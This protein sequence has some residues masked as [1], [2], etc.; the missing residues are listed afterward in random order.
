MSRRSGETIHQ[1]FRMIMLLT[2]RVIWGAFVGRHERKRGTRRRGG[3]GR[4][5]GTQSETAGARHRKQSCDEI[6]ER[7]GKVVRKA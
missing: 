5:V 7:R 4:G 2:L 1:T 3:S 6:A